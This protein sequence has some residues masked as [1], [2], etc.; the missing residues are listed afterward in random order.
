MGTVV[1]YAQVAIPAIVA[2]DVA[3]SM[4][5]LSRSATMI[6]ASY[7]FLASEPVNLPHVLAAMAPTQFD[8]DEGFVVIKTA[9]VAE[10]RAAGEVMRNVAARAS[11]SAA[12]EASR[13]A[14]QRALEETMATRT[15]KLLKLVNMVATRLGIVLTEKE[16][17]T[18]IPVAG[19]VMNG[20]L[21]MAFHH[22]GHALAKDYFRTQI[23][24]DRYGREVVDDAIADATRRLA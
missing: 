14:V 7:G 22:V 5:L 21:N 11:R 23:L 16:L 4:T 2:A 6:S 10:L 8:S 12:A 3:A 1:P 18:L 20:G 24:Y 9:A 15:P 19:A 13:K 17:S